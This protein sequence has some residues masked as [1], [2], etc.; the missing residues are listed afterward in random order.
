V[1]HF[2]TDRSEAVGIG[3]DDLGTSAAG[4]PYKITLFGD[5]RERLESP[6]VGS[7]PGHPNKIAVILQ[8][9]SSTPNA[10]L[11]R[12]CEVGLP[13]TDLTQFDAGPRASVGVAVT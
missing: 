2:V 7:T 4:K 10:R 8:G 12:S 11:S 1:S 6:S 13:L 5:G 3:R 9:F